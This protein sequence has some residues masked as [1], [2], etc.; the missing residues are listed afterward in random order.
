MS[1]D[2]HVGLRSGSCWE[3][4]LWSTHSAATPLCAT[5]ASQCYQEEAG[6]HSVCFYEVKRSTFL[7]K[8]SGR[9][10]WARL[11]VTC[12]SEINLQTCSVFPGAV[13]GSCSPCF[14][15][16][17]IRA[18]PQTSDC[19][20]AETL[21]GHD[22]LLT[23]W[24]SCCRPNRWGAPLSV[25][26]HATAPPVHTMSGRYQLC[27]MDIAGLENAPIPADYSVVSMVT[28]FDGV[29][30]GQ[31]SLTRMWVLNIPLCDVS[32]QY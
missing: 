17:C 31:V 14:V 1:V 8:G 29:R 28:E 21:G 6:L 9:C 25:G 15:P 11:R 10:S 3:K 19:D 27:F 7:S 16:V 32:I 5:A 2:A 26:A 30:V 12:G 4:R 23:G 13:V 22:W 24:R 20:A 18:F